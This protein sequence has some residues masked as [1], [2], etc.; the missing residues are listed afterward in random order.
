MQQNLY[1]YEFIA[2]MIIS[3][4][5]A[6]IIQTKSEHGEKFRHTISPLI[7]EPLILL[8]LEEDTFVFFRNVVLL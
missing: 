3:M 5:I 4:R 7:K 8:Q 6:R 1:R 2:I